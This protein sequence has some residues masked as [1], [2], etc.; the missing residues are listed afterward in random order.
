MYALEASLLINSKP[1]NK[2]FYLSFS[3]QCEE[4]GPIT[5]KAKPNPELVLGELII[6]ILHCFS[7]GAHY[8][9]F[10]MENMRIMD[11]MTNGI[12]MKRNIVLPVTL[13]AINLNLQL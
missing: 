10:A 7:H 4:K 12:K 8:V 2:V 9:L 6:I 11:Y 1:E 5:F 13:Q 3:E